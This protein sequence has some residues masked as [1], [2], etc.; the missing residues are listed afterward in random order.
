LPLLRNA[1]PLAILVTAGAASMT[2]SAPT[3]SVAE[4]TGLLAPDQIIAAFK[5]PHSVTVDKVLGREIGSAIGGKIHAANC[6]KFSAIPLPTVLNSSSE[7]MANNLLLIWC[8]AISQP[9]LLIGFRILMTIYTSHL[10]LP[11]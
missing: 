11:P 7:V 2:V 4:A 9:V 1:R 3:S 10:I 5:A 8:S 6:V